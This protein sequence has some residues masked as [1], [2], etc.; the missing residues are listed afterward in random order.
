MIGESI[1]DAVD[2]YLVQDYVASVISEWA[3]TNFGFQIEA[4]DLR[5][6]K[7]FDELER[8]I[9]DQARAEATTK[10]TATLGEFM[11]EDSDDPAHWDTKNMA[12]WMMSRFQVNLSQAQ[13]RRTSADELESMLR[14]AAVEQINARDC[15]GITAADPAGEPI[16]V[17][18]MATLHLRGGRW[19]ARPPLLRRA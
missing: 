11:G 18:A 12:S 19:H 14:A 15:A 17:S 4:Y 16:V 1:S 8:Y 2:K 9:K 3:T 7:H 13:I 10:I 5:G 6:Q